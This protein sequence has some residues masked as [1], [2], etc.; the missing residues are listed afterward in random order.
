MLQNPAQVKD[1][2]KVQDGLVDFNDVLSFTPWS[3]NFTHP[4][5]LSLP[6]PHSFISQYL[7]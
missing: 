5:F 7:V 4:T 2:Y 6:L 3:R 1:P